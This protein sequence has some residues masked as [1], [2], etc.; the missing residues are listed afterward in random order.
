MLH[1]RDKRQALSGRF[2][3]EVAP[4]RSRLI[5]FQLGLQNAEGGATTYFPVIRL[6]AHVA[7]TMPKKGSRGEWV[8]RNFITEILDTYAEL[9]KDR[10]QKLIDYSSRLVDEQRGEQ[11]A[12]N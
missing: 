10:T 8:R 3:F 11:R 2:K 9:N 12:A 6:G 1:S 5:K 4:M 7:S